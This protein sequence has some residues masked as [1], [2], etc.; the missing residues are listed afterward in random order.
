MRVMTGELGQVQSNGIGLHPSSQDSADQLT[1]RE[2]EVLRS[3]ATGNSNKIIAS[4]LNITEAKVKGDMESILA[5]LDANDR[6]HAVTMLGSKRPALRTLLCKQQ[7]ASVGG[8]PCGGSESSP[9][10]RWLLRARFS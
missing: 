5:K 8:C 1:D 9:Q 7:E 10:K 3:V 6:T 4:R 2:I